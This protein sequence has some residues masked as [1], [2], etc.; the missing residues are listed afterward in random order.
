M[1]T[2]IIGQIRKLNELKNIKDEEV[3]PFIEVALDEL[4]FHKISEIKMTKAT[5]YMT[6]KLLGVKLWHRIQQRANQYDET[7]ESFKDVEKW[8]D[9][10]EDRS[11]IP[12]TPNNISFIKQS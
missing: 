1:Y 12:E 11:C 6:L 3:I 2:E 4:Q 10:W 8:E 7:L 9:Y 5:A